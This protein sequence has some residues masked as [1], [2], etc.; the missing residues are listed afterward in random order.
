M[1]C[2]P[3]HFKN[4]IQF[5]V[6]H[7]VKGCSMV[8][9]AEVDIFLELSC[10]FSDPTDVGNWS[11]VPLHFLNPARTSGSSWFMYCWSLAWRI[12]SI[13]LL[14]SEMSA[15]V[16]YFEHSLPLPF[17]GIGIKTDLFCKILHKWYLILSILFT[18][19]VFIDDIHFDYLTKVVTVKSLERELKIM[20]V[21]SFMIHFHPVILIH[22]INPCLNQLLHWIA[23]ILIS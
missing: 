10:F 22:S 5:I 12:L 15:V 20:C 13:T 2:Y 11:L 16:W 4:F 7:T 18:S 19:T 9:E 17:F 14:A 23:R 6:I 8:N 21:F 3:Y 1:A